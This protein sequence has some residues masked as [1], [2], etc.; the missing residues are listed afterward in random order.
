MFKVRNPDPLDSLNEKFD[1]LLHRSDK[2]EFVDWDY[3]DEDLYDYIV[4]H[5]ND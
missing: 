4:G 5:E 1:D 3:F 2:R